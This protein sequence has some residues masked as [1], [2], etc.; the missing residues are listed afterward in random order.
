MSMAAKAMAPATEVSVLATPEEIKR[1]RRRRKL[2]RQPAT[3]AAPD[4]KPEPIYQ[5]FMPPLRYDANSKVQPD[6]DPNLI[7]LVRRVR[8]RPTLIFQGKVEGDPVVA[9]ATPPPAPPASQKRGAAQKPVDE[10]AWNRV[11]IYWRKIWSPS[12]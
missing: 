2:I 4:E 11:K 6:F 10:S 1:R 9:Q 3:A 7:L 5:V 8:V 12:S